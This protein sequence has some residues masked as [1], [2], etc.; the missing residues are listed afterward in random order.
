MS[1]KNINAHVGK[2]KAEGEARKRA[3][4]ELAAEQKKA[5]AKAAMLAAA[6]S[7]SNE[8]TELIDNAIG[9]AEAIAAGA[10]TAFKAKDFERAAVGWGEALACLRAAK[11]PAGIER[12]RAGS[13]G[14]NN[15]RAAAL[16]QLGRHAEAE[17][18]ATEVL[19]L[20]PTNLKALYRRGSA[21]AGGAGSAK[22]WDGGAEAKL[23]GAVQDF[24]AVMAVSPENAKAAKDLAKAQKRLGSIAAAAAAEREV[25]A[26]AEAESAR[27]AKQGAAE[28]A[29]AAVIEAAAKMAAMSEDEQEEARTAAEKSYWDNKMADMAAGGGKVED[30]N[31]DKMATKW[32][33]WS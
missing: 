16:L 2:M 26:A 4:K 11:V 20:E 21:R 1:E 17:S 24:E 28:A 22:H 27:A 7:L 32:R 18:A 12:A 5:A 15:N 10:S 14:W 8:A 3:E 9:A 6:E 19:S 33:R 13:L 31:S 29:K 30:Y 25:V 23:R